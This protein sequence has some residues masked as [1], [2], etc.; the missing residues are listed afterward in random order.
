MVSFDPWHILYPSTS[1]KRK[2]LSH[3][4]LFVT[5]WTI[6][7][8]ELS[9][10]EYWSGQ[11]FPYPGDLPNPGI[12]LR[13]L[14]L[15]AGSL[16]AEPPGKPKKTGVGSLSILQQIFLTWKSNQHFLHCRQILYQLSYQV[17]YQAK[18]I[19]HHQ[20]TV[21]LFPLEHLTPLSGSLHSMTFLRR[22]PW[23]RRGER[24]KKVEETIPLKLL[25]CRVSSVT[26]SLR[27]HF[28]SK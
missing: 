19:F 12:E 8:M 14:A 16:P 24:S 21:L 28:F 22:W 26:G 25:T 7:S 20:P 5:P 11:P 9:R 18:V 6:Q 13:S 2:S 1:E 15:Q 17:K 4:R 27:L 23:W 3:V 10:P